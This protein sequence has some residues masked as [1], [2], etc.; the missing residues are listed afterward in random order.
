MGRIKE[1]EAILRSKPNAVQQW[2]DY[3]KSADKQAATGKLRGKA[4]TQLE[5]KLTKAGMLFNALI[6]KITH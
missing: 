4:V 1:E 6:N 5:A 2:R 3:L